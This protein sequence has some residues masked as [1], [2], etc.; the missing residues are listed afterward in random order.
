MRGISIKEFGGPEVL[1]IN[2]NLKVPQPNDDQLLIKVSAAGVNPVD[3]YIRSGSFPNSPS[4]PFTPGYDAAGV[5]EKV[6]KNVKN[7]KKGE[8]VFTTC[9]FQGS[10]TYAE[11]VVANP[12][13]VGHL[14]NKLSF[15]EG[16][17]IGVPYYT[18]Y[19]AFRIL[20]GG[21]G[22]DTVLVHGASGAVGLASVQIAKSLGCT[23][24]GTAGTEEGLK[25]VKAN[26][27]DFVFNHREA[28]YEKKIKSCVPG[29]VTVIL[30]MLANVN[31]AKD[32]DIINRKGRISL[33]GSRGE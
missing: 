8:R 1:K 28:G 32:I 17:G 11:Y 27:A 7:F 5:V 33:I 21:K 12:I 24:I 25:L 18:A 30:E 22:G 4:L 14:G 2:E 3:T 23:V 15:E 19:K 16:A 26:G 31:L 29:G 6:G 10:G 9:N 13:H 20:V